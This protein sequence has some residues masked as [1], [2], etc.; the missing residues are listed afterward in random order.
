MNG[1]IK[2]FSGGLT[3]CQVG[4]KVRIYIPSELGYGDN[5]ARAARSNPETPSSSNASCL[6]S[7][8]LDLQTI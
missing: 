2:G 5:P 1:V 3:K 7:N 6:R 8:K 4:G